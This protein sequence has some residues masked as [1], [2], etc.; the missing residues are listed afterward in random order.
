M[1]T[2]VLPIIILLPL[3][4]GTTLVSW[5]K[6]FSRGVT[7][8]GAIGVSLSSF[9]LLLSQAPAIFDGAVMTQTWSWLPQLGIDFSFRLDSLGL[10]FALLISGIGTLI[11]IYA[12]YYLN[13]KNSLSK[14]YLLLMLFMAA[15]LGISLSNNLIIL[16]VFWELTSISSFLLV[17]YWSNYEAAQRGSR[18]ALTITGMG[19]L[20]MLGGFVLL[21]QITGTY[22]LDQ[23]LMM[24]EQIQSHHLFV[25]TLLLILLGAFT[26]SAQ[27][28]FH[29]WLPNAMAAPTPVSA[30]LHSATMVKAGLFLV[31]RLLPIFAGAA[32]F[33][34][35]VT[36]VGL[37]TLC[38]AAFFAIFKE[39][40]KGLLA[41]STIS[42]LGLIMCLLGIGS[43]LAVAA[44]IFH[45]INHATFK[46]A[47][48]MIA[49]IIDHE[50]G[51]RDLRKLSG[52]WQL[53]PFTATLTMITAA[54]MAGVP[55]TNGFLSKEMFFT[56]LVASLSGPLMV[57]SAIVATLAGIFAVAYSIRLVHGVFFDGPLGKQVP[58]KDAHEPAFG[59]RAPATLLA[60]LCILVGLL[61]ALLVEKIVNSTTQATTQNF[62]F[63]GTHLALWHGFNL[64]LLMSV[65]SLL[66]GTIFY[67]SLAKG[68][69]LR[70]ID[71]DPKLGR[72]QGRVLFDLFLKNLLLN[73]RRFRRSTEN[74]KL[75]SYLLWIVIFTVGLVGL[76]LLSNAVGTGTRELTHAP[77]LAI[78]LWLL[79]F[80]SC[81]MLLWFHHERIKAVLISGAVGL[82]VTM[83][84]IGFSAPDLALTQIT[85]DV[86][87][88]VLLLMSLS[89][90]PQLTPYESS[91]TRRWRDAI[92]A[93]G[94]G[95]GIAAIAWLIMT[96]D[97]NSISWFFL[98]QSIPL[99]GGTNVVNVILVDF[100]GFDTFGEITVLGIAAIGVLSL[101][102]GMRAHGTTMTQGLT[103]R[104]NPSPLML[105]ITAS[106]ILPVALVVSL[107][108]FLRGHNLPG[109]GFIAG[110]V[111]SLALI[112]QYI[113]VGQD[114]TEQLL[115]AKS[116]RLYEIWIGIGLTI[117]GLTGIAAWFWSR[118]FL[119]SAHIYVSPPI[120]GEMHLAS[121][122]LFDVGVYV[123][124]VGATMLMISVLGD[125]RH[126]SMT[127]PVPRG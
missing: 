119:T 35:I 56:E 113:A 61:P 51:T 2:S 60:I 5:L 44:A 38:M 45:I 10:L 96:R 15:M 122:A 92:I 42:H 73:S 121:A 89:L 95:L 125:S 22:Q 54:S 41:Y 16:L 18:M 112:I 71:L 12:Y 81:W 20:A 97:H 29:F 117:A 118:P 79:L 70:E 36:F 104:F 80:S 82:V 85:V 78:I 66:G 62:A 40:L 7:A 90:L 11:Y 47:L 114:K 53:L 55:L 72:L 101:M 115:G 58:N 98:Q 3:V 13:P 94:G 102:D 100:R 65:I 68:G 105:R 111:T 59:M 63:E 120:I 26:K 67:F 48:F 14:L 74:G 1:D 124:V 28:P 9:L 37:F 46:A 109:G 99:G 21:G 25:P 34:N 86:V 57:G 24:T 116:G 32:L 23:I 4:L 75:Q 87:T 91:P 43:P 107:Y 69:V 52:L 50:S 83:V 19:G 17:G 30:Y 103:Y 33:H 123:T 106:W 27:F 8:L 64:P 77:A 93:L 31:A 84:F 110:L 127:G 6:Q 76:P 88:T 49:G 126:S 108:I 39:D